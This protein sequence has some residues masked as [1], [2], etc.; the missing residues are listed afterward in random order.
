MLDPDGT[1][2]EPVACN[3]TAPMVSVRPSPRTCT[4]KLLAWKATPWPNAGAATR[5]TAQ[6]IRKLVT[7]VFLLI[8]FF[9]VSFVVLLEIWFRSRPSTG[10]V[11]SFVRCFLKAV[12]S[13]PHGRGGPA[14]IEGPA[15]NFYFIA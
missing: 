1:V 8:W 12:T 14:T 15:K 5:A 4:G 6:I 2:P 9:S 13:L 7:A 10:G 3:T 11:S